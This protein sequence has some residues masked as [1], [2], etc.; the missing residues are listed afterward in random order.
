MLPIGLNKL[1]AICKTVL[2][3]VVLCRVELSEGRVVVDQ[4]T[5][6]FTQTSAGPE[7]PRDWPYSVLSEN[8][9]FSRLELINITKCVLIFM[10]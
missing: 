1:E 9:I 7:T 4:S 10:E 6:W 8:C 5:N 2:E 3:N